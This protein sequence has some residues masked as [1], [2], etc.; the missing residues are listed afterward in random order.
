MKNYIFLIFLLFAN[1][2]AKGKYIDTHTSYLN[3][4]AKKDTISFGGVLRTFNGYS[5]LN[6]NNKIPKSLDSGE[7]NKIQIY[8]K[9]FTSI[10]NKTISEIKYRNTHLKIDFDTY[11][12]GEF[13]ENNLKRLLFFDKEKLLPLKIELE[14][15]KYEDM[16]SPVATWIDRKINVSYTPLAK[17]LDSDGLMLYVSKIVTPERPFSRNTIDAIIQLNSFCYYFDRNKEKFYRKGY[18]KNIKN[19]QKIKKLMVDDGIKIEELNKPMKDNK[20]V[21][22]N[23]N[24]PVQPQKGVYEWRAN[25]NGESISI[26][27]GQVGRQKSVFKKGTLKRGLEELEKGGVVSSNKGKTIDTR[28]IVGT[29]IEFFIS[30]GY[31]VYWEHLDNNS[32]KELEHIKTKKP[33]LQYE[34][35]K[36]V[37]DGIKKNI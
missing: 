30:K 12:L 33:I 16:Y 27:I 26:Y 24:N 29:A 34:D 15:K 36:R 18:D 3:I 32:D 9:E 37:T 1:V 11:K 20:I 10:W 13:P 17:K 5:E 8:T 28:F 7:S 6:Q 25:K 22:L 19:C 35:S 31:T 23:V 21:L 2:Y 4:E 14:S